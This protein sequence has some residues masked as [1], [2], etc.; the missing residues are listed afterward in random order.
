[1]I[2]TTLPQP[3]PDGEQP[4]RR[5]YTRKEQESSFSEEKEAIL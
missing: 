2:Y 3:D 4:P 1:M 5:A